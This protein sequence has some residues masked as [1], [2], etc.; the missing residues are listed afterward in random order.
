MRGQNHAVLDD[1]IAGFNAR[2]EQQRV[3]LGIGYVGR[4][5]AKDS[6][7][8]RRRAVGVANPVE[9]PVDKVDAAALVPRVRLV[10]QDDLP[11]P[12]VLARVIRASEP[13]AFEP[14]GSIEVTRG[15]RKGDITD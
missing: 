6:T 14:L 15:N 4:I 3:R 11:L 5:A 9:F 8:V 1:H 12:L 10:G 2:I 13:V 7:V